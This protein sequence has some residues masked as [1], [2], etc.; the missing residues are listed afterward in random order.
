MNYLNIEILL[1]ISIYVRIMARV[2]KQ[3]SKP[4][5][6]Q[7]TKKTLSLGAAAVSGEIDAF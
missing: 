3:V 5:Y 1:V 4:S 6:T 2:S 7:P